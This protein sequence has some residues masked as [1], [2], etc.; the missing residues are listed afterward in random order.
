VPE[1]SRASGRAR[2]L[3]RVRPCPSAPVRPAVPERS[4][5]SGRARALPRVRPCPSAP[6]R[7]AVPERSRASGRARALPRVRPCQRARCFRQDSRYGDS[8][9]PRQVAAGSRM[10]FQ[11]A[12]GKPPMRFASGRYPNIPRAEKRMSG[13]GKG[14]RQQPETLPPRAKP[15][16]LPRKPLRTR[17]KQNPHGA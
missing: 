8:L 11:N 9:P 6:V 16:A 12:L 13:H 14:N 5:A 15:R 4:R 3:P 2:A 1:R 10:A 7:P 17:A